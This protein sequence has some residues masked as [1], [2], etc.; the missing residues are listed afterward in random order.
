MIDHSMSAAAWALVREQDGV[1]DWWQL[2]EMGFSRHAIQQRIERARLHPLWRGVFAVGRPE[3]TER[4]RWRAALLA[5]DA[6]DRDR[7][8]GA[9]LSHSSAAALFRW[10]DALGERYCPAE[11][12]HVS[13]PGERSRL[14]GIR[15]HRRTPMPETMVVDGIR[16]T[17]PEWTLVDLAASIRPLEPLIRACNEADRVGLVDHDE[18]TTLVESLPG[19]RGIRKLR[20]LL[21][22]ERT[23]S[24]LERRF[25]RLIDAANLPRP[26]TQQK[27]LGFRV[28]F[29]WPEANLIVETDGLTYHRTPAEQAVDLKRAQ[30]LTLAKYRVVRFTNAQVRLEPRGVIA[31]MRGLLE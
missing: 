28:D 2:R 30:V 24:N 18:F 27:I 10:R 17:T 16:V 6:G 20:L 25:L 13:V 12:V 9:A 26:L 21:G 7:E 14:E 8:R 19:R 29:F 15:C 4:G 22:I 11:P 31:T 3:V 5:T 23:D 1:I